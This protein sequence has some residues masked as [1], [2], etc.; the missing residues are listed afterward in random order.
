MLL[1][2]LFIVI[3]TGVAVPVVVDSSLSTADV[4]FV[5]VVIAGVHVF[6]CRAWYALNVWRW[7]Y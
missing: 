2:L 6:P 3:N 1:L 4:D 7:R 5:V